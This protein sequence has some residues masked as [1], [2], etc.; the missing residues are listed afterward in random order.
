MTIAVG[1]SAVRGE[2]VDSR[3]LG[4]LP[5]SFSSRPLKKQSSS[6]HRGRA[7]PVPFMLRTSTLRI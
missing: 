2:G 1:H 3:R 5:S 4:L 6:A 7:R